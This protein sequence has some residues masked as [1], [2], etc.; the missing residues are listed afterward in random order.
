M[1]I[2]LISG[3]VYVAVLAAFFLLKIFVH[4]LFFD[5]LVYFFALVGSFEMTRALKEKMTKAE[6]GIVLSFAAVCIPACALF[7]SVLWGGGHGALAAAVCFVLFAIALLS[8][9][10]ARH[11]ETTLESVG[12]S[13]LS[14]VYP[15][16]LLCVLVLC[17]HFEGSGAL[18][19]FAFHSDLAILFVFVVSPV[20][21][22]LAY[23]FGRLLKG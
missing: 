23:V 18:S 14:G 10:V 7:E 16:L 6:R 17:N 4:D 9:L 8:L 12:V 2:R 21:D 1:K 13:L 20:A 3:S 11:T 15:T 5:A 22:S 19:G